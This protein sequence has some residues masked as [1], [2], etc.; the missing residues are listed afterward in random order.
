MDPLI[1]LD[2]VDKLGHYKGDPT[3]V[4]LELLDPQQND[5]FIDHYLE[6]PLDL[7]KAM[8]ICTA[9]EE[10]MIPAPLLDRMEMIRFRSYSEEERQIITRKFLLPKIVQQYNPKN[11]DISFN[12]DAVDHVVK[13]PQVRQIEKIIAK[14]TRKAVTAV[15]VYEQPSYAVTAEDVDKIKSNYKDSLSRRSMGF[16]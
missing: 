6:L 16:K 7:S 1:L 9:N 15:H 10:K 2:E 12:D 4:L 13:I 5:H 8:F 11:F 14:L 3:A